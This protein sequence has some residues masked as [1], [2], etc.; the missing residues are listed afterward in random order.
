MADPKVPA[1]KKHHSVAHLKR[2][3]F[4]CI[5]RKFDRPKDLYDAAQ[6]YFEM[7]KGKTEERISSGK[8]FTVN[9]PQPIGL[10]GLAAHLGVHRNVLAQNYSVKGA[11]G[12]I[13][14][15][16]GTT[17]SQV[18]EW[19]RSILEA[20]SERRL[21]SGDGPAAGHIFNLVNN[22][23]WLDVRKVEHTGKIDHAH[24]MAGPAQKMIN[25]VNEALEGEY[26]PLAKKG[27]GS[28]AAE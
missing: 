23:K 5:A 25:K 9:K 7:C 3:E 20:D 28:D 11:L 10:A 18:Y 8:Q 4:G 27:L 1:K 21:L 12:A 22:F 15:K 24:G 13:A 17:F 6:E 16:D 14:D 26:D 19:I 2:D